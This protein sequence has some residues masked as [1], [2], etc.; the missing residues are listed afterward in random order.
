MM[1]QYFLPSEWAE[2]DAVLLTWPHQQTDWADRLAQVEPVYL[3]LIAAISQ[4]QSVVIVCH[5]DAL[6]QRVIAQ[7]T[8]RQQD[9]AK[10]HFVIALTND[11][12]ARDHGP[13]T[14]IDGQHSIRVLNFTFNGW[15]NKYESALDNHI[16]HALIDQLAITEYQHLDF[17][18]EGG[19]I[20]SD[21]QGCL[22]TTKACLLN[23]NRNPHLSQQQIEDRLLALF[24]GKKIIWLEDGHLMGD[25]TDAHIDT[26]ARF[27]P[28]NQ[29][30]FQGCQ[31]KSDPHY[32][33]LNAMKQTLQDCRNHLEQP[34]HLVELP[35]PTAQYNSDNERL[36]ATYAN[37]LII[38]HAVLV[39]TYQVQED[40]IALALFAKAFP[41]YQVIAIN[42]QAI[43]EQFGSLHCLTMQLP[44]GFLNNINTLDRILHDI[45]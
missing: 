39:P 26:L 17:I 22:L 8:E 44:K 34:Y 1:N 38:N 32:T 25:D 16:N 42:C 20:E 7:L 29:I 10:I 2:Q 9:F 6:K 27:A 24:N 18:L 35:L 45:H 3:T 21:G 14:L 43:I 36:P 15:G 31:D 37:F 13:F 5:N 33:S 4:Y 23:T 11:T 30:I 41:N 12:W 40:D 28:D 19:A